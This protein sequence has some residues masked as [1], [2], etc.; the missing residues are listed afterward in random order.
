[1]YPTAV[2]ALVALRKSALEHHFTYPSASS[3]LHS[4]GTARAPADSFLPFHAHARPPSATF[5]STLS[6]DKRGTDSE[7]GAGVGAGGAGGRRRVVALRA[8]ESTCVTES[9]VDVEEKD[10]LV[11]D[12]IEL[13][14][15]GD[16]R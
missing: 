1:M 14:G 6:H 3:A 15:L 4:P 2:I 5:D 8:A 10:G 9:A 12:E 16:A 7:D 11:A 13:E